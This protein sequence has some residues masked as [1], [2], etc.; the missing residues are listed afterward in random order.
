ML[1]IDAPTFQSN[2]LLLPTA[3]ANSRKHVQVIPAE[4]DKNRGA[5]RAEFLFVLKIITAVLAVKDACGGRT[6]RLRRSVDP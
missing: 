2:V 1:W 5:M 4:M 3:P 6:R